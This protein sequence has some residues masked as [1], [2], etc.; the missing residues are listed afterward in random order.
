MLVCDKHRKS[1]DVITQFR[2]A[3]R[4][5]L[6]LPRDNQKPCDVDI[7]VASVDPLF[8]VRHCRSFTARA[9]EKGYGQE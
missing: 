5:M 2:V 9:V 3:V 7:G 8:G 4:S 1:T 6:E